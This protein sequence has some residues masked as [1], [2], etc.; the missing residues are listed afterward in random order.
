MA[1]D[2]I[3]FSIL[4]VNYKTKRLTSRCLGLIKKH[5]VLAKTNVIVVDNGSNDE[6]LEYLKSLE[7]ITLLERKQH[8]DSPA[9]ISHAQA[10]DE[11]MQHVRTRYVLLIHSDTL[12]YN[13]Q[14]YDHLFAQFNSRKVVAVG[15]CEQR[16]RKVYKKF[17]RV[18]KK[19]TRYYYR[20]GLHLLGL[21]NLEP[22]PFID[23]YLK[24]FCCLWDVGVIRR[25]GLNFCADNLNPSYGMQDKLIALGY[26]LVRLPTRQIFSYLDHVQSGTVVEMAT[27]EC[28]NPRRSRSY[29]KIMAG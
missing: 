16:H 23:S 10:L 25:H 18:V 2:P 27:T 24:S 7:W 26:R 28:S 22:K 3:P 11:G 29:A 21:S 15:T 12:I 6:S 9:H 17:A 8:E 13:S 19:F 1:Q 4:L 5:A 14:I 20:K